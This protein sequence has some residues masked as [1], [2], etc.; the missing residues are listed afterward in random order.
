MLKN[1]SN[2]IVFAYQKLLL[3]SFIIKLIINNALV[4][5]IGGATFPNI[6]LQINSH[7]NL[8][9]VD[10]NNDIPI[11]ATK[12]FNFKPSNNTKIYI[13][14]GIEFVKNSKK[15]YDLIINDVFNTNPHDNTSD[16]FE[17]DYFIKLVKSK[18]N[19]NGLYVENFIVDDLEKTLKYYSNIKQNFKCVKS[20]STYT[21]F[22]EDYNHVIFMSDCDIFNKKNQIIYNLNKFGISNDKL[23]QIYNS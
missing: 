3:L 13:Q 21:H 1:N 17:S 23:F 12:Y 16:R 2:L 18:L 10:N 7:I 5:G 22:N 8:D 11:I 20:Y 9:I 15:K 19:N 6:L 14:D 4:I